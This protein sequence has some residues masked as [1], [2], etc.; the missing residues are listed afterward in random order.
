MGFGSRAARCQASALLLTILPALHA[1][2]CKKIPERSGTVPDLGEEG[3]LPRGNG[4]DS[5]GRHLYGFPIYC[6][7]KLLVRVCHGSDNSALESRSCS[8]NSLK[9]HSNLHQKILEGMEDAKHHQHHRL[10][11]IHC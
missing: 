1:S 6:I 2:P 5:T 11:P 4:L 7:T 8:F 3:Q 9:M 10:S